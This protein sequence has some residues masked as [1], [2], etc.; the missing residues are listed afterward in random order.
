MD[1]YEQIDYILESIFYNRIS[2]LVSNKCNWVSNGNCSYSRH[3]ILSRNPLALCEK[4]KKFIF[5]K[6]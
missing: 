4:E 2:L 5:S 1:R 3:N 6:V